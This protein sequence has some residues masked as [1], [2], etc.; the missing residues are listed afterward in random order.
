MPLATQNPVS[1]IIEFS[2]EG[3]KVIY[4]PSNTTSLI[5]PLDQRALG[6]FK[7]HSTWYSMERN[8]GNMEENLDREGIRTVWKDYTTEDAIIVKDKAMKAIK[9][10]TIT[11]C[12]SK[13]LSRCT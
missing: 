8:I 7:A 3:I 6:T 9:L 13:L 2:I 12:W 4:F 11:S 5:Q 1:T 10:K